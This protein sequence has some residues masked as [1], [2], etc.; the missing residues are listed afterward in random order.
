M[1]LNSTSQTDR[2]SV[3]FA[4]SPK[5]FMDILSLVNSM[6]PNRIK[7]ILESERNP[8]IFN[9]DT[10]TKKP[11]GQI[12]VKNA[13]FA[14]EFTFSLE[15]LYTLYSDGGIKY[16]YDKL[17]YTCSRKIFPLLYKYGLKQNKVSDAV[18]EALH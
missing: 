8:Y 6:F 10:F 4:N 3:H 12:E 14:Y 2:K 5:Y 11:N 1:Q 15:D 18:R 16:D 9:Y 7:E 13:F 17:E